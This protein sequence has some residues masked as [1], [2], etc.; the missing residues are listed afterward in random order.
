MSVVL[1]RLEAPTEPASLP[2]HVPAPVPPSFSA[3]RDSVGERGALPVIAV[4]G[5]R[6]KTTVV[7][8]LDAIFRQA[9]LRT[10]IWTDAGVEIRGRRQRS[11]LGAWGQAMRRLFADS[12]DIAIQELDWPTVHAVGLPADAYPVAAVT[13]ICVN[14][15]RCLVRPETRLAIRAYR[16]VRE[17]A[18]RD[19]VLVLNAD[20]YAVG[21]TEV[22]R[23]TPALLVGLNPEAPILR[24]HLSEGGRAAWVEDGWIT[25]GTVTASE[26]ICP[27]DALPISLNGAAS[28]EV[29]NGLLAAAIAQVCGIDRAVAATALEG[30]RVPAAAAGSFN[31]V[32]LGDAV[33]IVDRPAPSWFL[34]PV[35]RAVRHRPHRRLIFVV[36][37]LHDVPDDDLNE[38]GRL[39]GRSGDA[40]VLHSERANEDRTQ[41]LL[42]GV[43]TRSAPMVVVRQAS[44]RQ[45]ITKA[46]KLLRA[47][48]ILLVLADQP[49]AALKSLA[50]AAESDRERAAESAGS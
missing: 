28:F 13:N 14:N 34:R 20:D 33:A 50:R 47:G 11:E 12:L 2:G 36:G 17:A 37:D 10:A 16:R 45:A 22:E 46:I 39:I 26:R 8:L 21:G 35:L 49:E 43:E 25:F 48:D 18:R 41:A 30:F 3:W 24:G 4:A 32:D 19:G 5:S 7:R 1:D 44:E 40:I 6:G 23:E 9:G 31:V 27:V 15:D 38:V 42:A 29:Q